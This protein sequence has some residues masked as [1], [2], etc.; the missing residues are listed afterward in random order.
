MDAGCKSQ[1]HQ[2]INLV[3]LLLSSAAI[4][5]PIGYDK[6]MLQSYSTQN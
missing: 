6:W 4:N 1:I 3:L 2:S 5:F